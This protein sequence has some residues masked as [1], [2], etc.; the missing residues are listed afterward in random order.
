MCITS[1]SCLDF[2]IPD[3]TTEL[4]LPLISAGIPDGASFSTEDFEE[5][6]LNLNEL[7]KFP[8]AIFYARAKGGSTIDTGIQ[9]GDLL[10]IDKWKMVCFLD[11]E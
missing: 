7:I 1:G 5:L 6:T 11:S 8:A 3:F 9:D 4:E 10:L 2:F